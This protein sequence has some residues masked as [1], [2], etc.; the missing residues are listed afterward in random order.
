MTRTT[1]RRVTPN[2]PK[3]PIHSLRVPDELWDKAKARA[4][5]RDET[6]SDAIR[7]F[8]ERYTR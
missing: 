7:K 1:L 5:E 4:K 2:Q 3:T 8:L 6:L